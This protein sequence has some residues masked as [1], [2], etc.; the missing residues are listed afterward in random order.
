[1][2]LP[3]KHKNPNTD[4]RKIMD[5]LSSKKVASRPLLA[6]N[7]LHQPAFNHPSVKVYENL[8]NSSTLYKQSFML[9]N[10]HN[11]NNEQIKKIIEVLRSYRFK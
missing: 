6:G 8:E 4:I 2:A 11:Y 9:G 7:T 3:I 1:M 5:Y 10:H